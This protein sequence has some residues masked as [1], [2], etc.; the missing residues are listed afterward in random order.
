MRWFFAHWPRV[1]LALAAVLAVALVVALAA[2][3]DR[4]GDVRFVLTVSLLT[5]LL[6][7]TEEY[8]WPGGFPQMANRVMFRSDL[9]DRFPLDQRTS[10]IINVGLGWTTYA[11]AAVVGE[12]ALW[13]GIATLVVSAGNVVAHTL[14]FNIRGRTLYNPGL[15][16]SWLLF[17]PTIVWFVVLVARDDLVDAVDVV[18]GVLLGMAINYLGVVRLI[19]V[20]GRRDTAY[21]FPSR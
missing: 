4:A 2:D 17:V 3:P 10:W 13:L 15:A 11:V 14:L 16:T 12:R 18:V 19:V 20:L 6:H 1:G 5:L 9:P 21:P 7:Q 8:V